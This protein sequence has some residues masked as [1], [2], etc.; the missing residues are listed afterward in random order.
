MS[1]FPTIRDVSA[2]IG[3]LS[4][5]LNPDTQ[6]HPSCQ[7]AQ[8]FVVQK[9]TGLYDVINRIPIHGAGRVLAFP[10]TPNLGELTDKLS[11]PCVTTELNTIICQNSLLTPEIV[12]RRVGVGSNASCEIQPYV[13]GAARGDGTYTFLIQLSLMRS[14]D[15]SGGSS[16]SPID[17]L[18]VLKTAFKEQLDT[19]TT[20][21]RTALTTAHIEALKQGLSA[22]SY[23]GESNPEDLQLFL[24]TLVTCSKHNLDI[25]IG[26]LPPDRHDGVFVLRFDNVRRN[27]PSQPLVVPCLSLVHEDM[28]WSSDA[29]PDPLH[30]VRAS[31]WVCYM[32]SDRFSCV[33]I[34]HSAGTEVYPHFTYDILRAS[35]RRRFYNRSSEKKKYSSGV[36]RTVCIPASSYSIFPQELEGSRRRKLASKAV[37]IALDA[38]DPNHELI[39]G[40]LIWMRTGVEPVTTVQFELFDW[41]AQSDAFGLTDDNLPIPEGYPGDLV[42]S[43]ISYE[44]DLGQEVSPLI[45]MIGK[46]VRQRLDWNA[47]YEE[48]K[49]TLDL[50]EKEHT[51]RFTTSAKR[52]KNERTFNSYL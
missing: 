4:F 19:L 10:V 18:N 27:D 52:F 47:I 31:Y 39:V 1:N 2:D 34:K 21:T 26:L 40:N 35:G 41:R 15:G 50:P 14:K 49:E 33:G 3:C 37:K 46:T 6:Y 13:V 17:V 22:L 20:G 30:Q 45:A 32:G 44:E 25:I 51:G 11:S 5:S 43:V 7:D 38:Q 12:Y 29:L 42:S 8:L 28:E 9:S 16:I 23:N 24:N 36:D 48:Y